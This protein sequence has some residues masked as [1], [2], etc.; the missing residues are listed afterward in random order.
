MATQM[1]QTEFLDFE[2][3]VTADPIEE[4]KYLLKCQRDKLKMDFTSQSLVIL[5]FLFFLYII[6][7]IFSFTYFIFLLLIFMKANHLIKR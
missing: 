4:E 1:D 7:F 6:F 5:F 3:Q 2:C